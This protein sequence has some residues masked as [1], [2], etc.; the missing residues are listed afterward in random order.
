[1]NS[2]LVFVIQIEVDKDCQEGMRKSFE[3]WKKRAQGAYAARIQTDE[4]VVQGD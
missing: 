3:E 4:V 1:M 2:K